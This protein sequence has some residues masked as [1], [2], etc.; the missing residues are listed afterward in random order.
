MR[1]GAVLTLGLLRPRA[2]HPPPAGIGRPASRPPCGMT[3][4]AGEDPGRNADALARRV[5]DT[6]D[7][8]RQRL[9]RALHD[10]VQQQLV[11]VFVDLGRAHQLWHDDPDQAHQLVAQASEWTKNAID[12]LRPFV[13]A[14]YPSILGTH[15]LSAA[16]D[17]LATRTTFPVEIDADGI[18]VPQ[19]LASSIYFLCA[20]ALDVYGLMDPISVHV[21]V[22]AAGDG[23][24]VISLEMTGT[25]VPLVADDSFGDV[26]DRI[27][28]LGGTMTLGTSS[29]TI[30]LLARLPSEHPDVEP[31]SPPSVGDAGAGFR[32]DEYNDSE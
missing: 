18:V 27:D 17:S 30:A 26:R 20:D 10:G 23:E 12:D 13:A 2:I 14:I 5:L 31:S 21:V 32:S 15:G 24:V 6:A 11:N 28:A 9:S 3:I 8:R 19:P 16:L 1:D 22:G 25:D 29:R 4:T 7:R